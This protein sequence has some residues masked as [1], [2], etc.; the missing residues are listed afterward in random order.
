V[1]SRLVG[2]K[3]MDL[4][5]LQRR[6]G[7]TV[8]FLGRLSDAEVAAEYA[9][10]RALIFP[11][12]EDFGMTP[13]ECMASGRPVV[14][15]GAGGALETVVDGRTGVLFREQTAESLAAALRAVCDLDAPPAALRAYAQQFDTA[16]FRDR[17]RRFLDAAQGEYHLSQTDRPSG[18]L[19]YEA[20][21]SYPH[22]AVPGQPESKLPPFNRK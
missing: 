17:M 10:C 16:V 8:R 21:P 18:R 11:G 13:I 4:A 12:E 14:A 9:R 3:R 20:S 6:A 19:G 7:P 1:V 15:F 5:G 2:Y 22:L